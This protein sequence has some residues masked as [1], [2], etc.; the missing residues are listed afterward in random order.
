MKWHMNPTDM[1]AFDHLTVRYRSAECAAAAAIADVSLTVP[2]GTVCAIIGPSGCGKSTLLKTLCRIQPPLGGEVLLDGR[3]IFSEDSRELAQKVAILPQNPMA[4]A[5]LTV[6]ELVNYGRAPH[7]SRFFARTTQEDKR[8]V[9]WALQET[10]ITAFADRPVEALSGGQRQRAWIAMAIAQDT[11]ILFLDE[12]TSFL[13]VAHQMDVLT[14]V[15]H[16]NTAYGKTIVMVIHEINEAARFADYLLAM[17][18]GTLLYEG[19]PEEVFTKEMLADVFGIDAELL[20]DP[21][22]DRPYCIPYVSRERLAGSASKEEKA[23]A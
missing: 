14:L 20:R 9:E 12:P 2:Q 22:T 10:D 19:T 18:H 15:R 4:P 11:E 1:I 5:G 3:S 16:L 23:Y 13:D 6:R 7:R 17:R 21:R 8:M